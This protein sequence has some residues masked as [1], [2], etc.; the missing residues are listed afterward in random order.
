MNSSPGVAGPRAFSGARLGSGRSHDAEGVL[1]N[2]QLCTG[3]GLALISHDGGSAESLPPRL[4]AFGLVLVA[5]DVGLL[6]WIRQ[7]RRHWRQ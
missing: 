7:L 2:T 4:V 1:V 6:V 3:S 5:F